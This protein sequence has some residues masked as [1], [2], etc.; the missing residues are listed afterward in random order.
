MTITKITA[1]L[2]AGLAALAFAGCGD[3]D[4]GGSAAAT[5]TT[6]SATVKVTSAWARV[7][8]PTAKQGAVYMAIAAPEGDTLVNASVPTSIAGKTELHETTGGDGEMMNPDEMTPEQMAEQMKKMREVDSI[9]IPAGETVMLKP[10]GYH[11]MLLELAGP[12]EEGETFPVTLEFE[13]AGTVQ[14]EATA[15]KMQM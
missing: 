7:T 9:E 11:V 2:A 8:A 4:D 1:A 14:V 15:R 13:Q 3:D 12:I 6:A 10:G 5:A